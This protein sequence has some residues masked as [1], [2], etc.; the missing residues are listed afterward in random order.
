MRSYLLSLFLKGSFILLL[1]ALGTVASAEVQVY[2]PG[3]SVGV[4]GGVVV[5][6]PGVAVQLN[7]GL[8]VVVNNDW[9]YRYYNGQYW[10]WTANGWTYFVNGQWVYYTAQTYIYP[11]P[12]AVAPVVPVYPRRYYYPGPYYGRRGVGVD[13]GPVH[14]R[15]G[16]GWLW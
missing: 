14:V 7:P 6:A 13:V 5:Q 4:G 15:V 10:Y 12:V 1:F 8:G 3:V 11:A 16:G 9:N 2:A